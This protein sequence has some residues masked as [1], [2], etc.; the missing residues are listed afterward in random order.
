M[1]KNCLYLLLLA[2][3][4]LA[5]ACTKKDKTGPV[6]PV[7][8]T[9]PPGPTYVGVVCGHVAVHDLFGT[10]FHPKNAEVRVALEGIG[11]V[12]TDTNGYFQFDSVPTGSYVLSASGVG[13][14]ATVVRNVQF[15]KDTCYRLLEVSEIPTFPLASVELNPTVRGG[16]DSFTIWYSGYERA[17]NLLFLVSTV[18][19]DAVPAGNYSMAYLRTLPANSTLHSFV[20]PAAEFRKAGIAAGTPVYYRVHSYVVNDKSAH[21]NIATGKWVYTAIGATNVKHSSAP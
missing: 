15:L 11:A 18:D 7:G 6:G 10:R 5:T 3:L 17:R 4:S 12:Y 2:I 20:I 1:R 9:G 19:D 16:A 14:G 8:P 21:L 13:I